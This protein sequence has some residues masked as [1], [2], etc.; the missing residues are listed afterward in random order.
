M[1]RR[2]AVLLLAGL[3]LAS[4]CATPRVALGTAPSPCFQALPVARDAVGRQGQFAGVKRITSRSLL[5]VPSPI[6]LPRRSPRSTTTLPS[7]S[8]VPP[9]SRGECLVAF[10]GS[11]DRSKIPLL[12][13][14]T[15]GRY[16]V[17]VVSIRTRTAHFVYFTDKLTGFTHL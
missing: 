15:S 8:T 7:G 9:Q 16:A 11:L 10:K 13:P 3:V 14:N 2:L 4:G 1:R 12:L 17:V 6:R 5:P